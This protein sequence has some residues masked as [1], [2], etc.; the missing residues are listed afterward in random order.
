MGAGRPVSWRLEASGE[1]EEETT[2][3][4]A[5]GDQ[6]AREGIVWPR[7]SQGCEGSGHTSPGPVHGVPFLALNSRPDAPSK[8]APDAPRSCMDAG[9]QGQAVLWHWM[10]FC[11]G[12]VTPRQSLILQ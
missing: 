9:R 6:W 7:G 11:P 8:S 12:M 5:A 4:R 10:A 3:S 2:P 1:E